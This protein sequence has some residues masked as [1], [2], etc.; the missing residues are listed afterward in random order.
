MFGFCPHGGG[1]GGVYVPGLHVPLVQV[2]GR[3]RAQ[4]PCVHRAEVHATRNLENES[5]G[6]NEVI[7]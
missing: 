4:L 7:N 5:Q 2:V 6:L 1:G 3:A